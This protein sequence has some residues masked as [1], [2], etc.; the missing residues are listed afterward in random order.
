MFRLPFKVYEA[1]NNE[2][3]KCKKKKKNWKKIEKF[4]FFW[5]NHTPTRHIE[6][7]VINSASSN[8]SI[9][10]NKPPSTNYE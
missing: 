7:K 9:M 6:Y 2:K 1:V 4:E 5:E 10:A 8:K 3:I